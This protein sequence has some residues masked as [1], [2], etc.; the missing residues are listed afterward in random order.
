MRGDAVILQA[1]PVAAA[2]GMALRVPRC[3]GARNLIRV[4][5]LTLAGR[6][7]PLL[8]H[9]GF[10]LRA[11][12]VLL[13]AL[14]ERLQRFPTNKRVRAFH[15]GIHPQHV[16]TVGA[17][18][19]RGL[20]LAHLGKVLLLAILL[21]L[22]PTRA[23][24]CLRLL[25]LP[26]FYP[27]HGATGVPLDARIW[28]SLSALD[29]HSTEN[30][31]VLRGSDGVDIPLE[32]ERRLVLG[33]TFVLKRPVEELHA[34]TSYTYDVEGRSFT[35]GTHRVASRSVDVGLNRDRQVLPPPWLGDDC[36]PP[37]CAKS[38]HVES[39]MGPDW[40]HFSGP[41][42]TPETWPFRLYPT[43][44]S[45][46]Y[47]LEQQC[48]SEGSAHLH[49]KIFGVNGTAL[50]DADM[51]RLDGLNGPGCACAAPW[52]EAAWTWVVVILLSGAFSRCRRQWPMFLT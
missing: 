44:H 29:I 49:V 23:D 6:W 40:L 1:R 35:T 10:V 15:V 47:G 43:Y 48:E 51:G 13:H 30:P 39:A 17:R 7:T 34:N 38:V 45:V 36:G 26:V 33:H 24:A 50:P 21:M 5:V 52:S 16:H 31:V 8:V 22:T 18:P 19:P 4:G 46:T 2:A 25:P 32:E 12:Q 9:R 41:G 27:V 11:E 14:G 28:V 3:R 20:G 42:G 37:R